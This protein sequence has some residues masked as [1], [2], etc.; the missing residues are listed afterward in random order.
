MK[1]LIVS[2]TAI[3]FFIFGA[4][5]SA[6]AGQEKPAGQEEQKK[7]PEPAQHE[8]KAP[9]KEAAKRPQPTAKTQP[10]QHASKP[11]ETKPATEPAQHANKT[12]EKKPAAQ[13]AQPAH[14]ASHTSTTTRTNTKSQG[15]TNT[16]SQQS[17]S[18]QSSKQNHNFGGHGGGHI[19]EARFQ[20]NFGSSHHFHMSQPQI[21]QGYSRFNYGGYYFG[22]YDP[23]PVGWGYTDDVYVDYIGGQYYLIDPEHSGLRLMVNVVI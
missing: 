2:G 16:H 7:E 21:Y 17:Q 11:Q 5:S 8:E 6:F 12:E 13:P 19:E 20:S 14:A 9:P 4:T 18:A 15:N 23:W 3:L 10:T 22:F 1:R